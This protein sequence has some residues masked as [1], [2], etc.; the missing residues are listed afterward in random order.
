MTDYDWN[1]IEAAL[2]SAEAAAIRS[3]SVRPVRSPKQSTILQQYTDRIGARLVAGDRGDLDQIREEYQEEE[4]RLNEAEKDM[5]L[6]QSSGRLAMLRSRVAASREATK[7]VA[8]RKDRA[9]GAELDPDRI[10]LDVA[11]AIRLKGDTVLDNRGTGTALE[12]WANRASVAS[13][14]PSVDHLGYVAGV[15][16]AFVWTNPSNNSVVID[17][18]SFV[19]LSGYCT[20]GAG[21]TFL[22][23][24]S[25]HLSVTAFL[26]PSLPF[27]PVYPPLQSGQT[28]LAEELSADGGGFLGLGE[29]RAAN[30]AGYYGV[31]HQKLIVPGGQLAVFEA[32]AYFL[33]GA[34]SDG[35]ASADFASGDFLVLCPV[36]MLTIV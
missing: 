5:A 24:N 26:Q 34:T 18:E 27:D 21:S 1:A 3:E 35:S 12:P 36:V 19:A 8:S 15:G 30:V 2:A 28:V 23:Q 25:T 7:S 29:V 32:G 11:S 4:R 17:V 9:L 22:G 31:F 14:W 16:F 6:E 10:V 20:V 13:A 33:A